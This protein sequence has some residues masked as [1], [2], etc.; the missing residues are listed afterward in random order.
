[1]CSTIMCICCCNK[2]KIHQSP[3][4]LLP[5][6]W[7]HEAVET[8]YPVM[9]SVWFFVMF[10]LFGNSWFF[11]KGYLCHDSWCHLR[12]G[13]KSCSLRQAQRSRRAKPCGSSSGGT[14]C[15]SQVPFR[16][17]WSW[18]V[19]RSC[20]GLGCWSNLR[21]TSLKLAGKLRMLPRV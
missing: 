13:K 20:L 19:V 12:H 18:K 15:R 11:G 7:V 17:R 3:W 6:F 1:M 16:P 4:R 14:E 8:Y 9:S 21:W 10:E 5:G 2:D